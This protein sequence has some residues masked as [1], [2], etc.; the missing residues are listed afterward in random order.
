MMTSRVRGIEFS[1]RIM[2]YNNHMAIPDL[3]VS[4][5]KLVQYRR[6]AM[7]RQ[8]ARADRIKPHMAQGWKIARQAARMLRAQYHATRVVAFGSLVHEV[9]FHEWSDIDIAAWGISPELTFRAIG[10]VMDLDPSFEINLVDVNACPPSLL[11]SI[12]QE[13]KDL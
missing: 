7:R 9:R 3:D 10:A 8:N 13:G 12:E 2:L 5:E 6:A 4:P 1:E 11:A